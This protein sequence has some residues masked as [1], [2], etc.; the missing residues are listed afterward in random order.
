M[1]VSP[2]NRHA[3]AFDNDA[4]FGGEAAGAQRWLVENR[5]ALDSSNAFVEQHGLPLLRRDKPWRRNRRLIEI[6]ATLEG[7]SFPP[8]TRKS[9]HGRWNVLGINDLGERMCPTPN[10]LCLNQ[11]PRSLCL[12]VGLT[13]RDIVQFGH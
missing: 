2:E 13:A 9:A 7:D 12:G 6:F 1:R 5:D 8:N 11:G 4:A 3:L 10:R